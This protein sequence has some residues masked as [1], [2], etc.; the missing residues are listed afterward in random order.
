VQFD[1][2]RAAQILEIVTTADDAFAA[3]ETR[4]A[5]GAAAAGDALGDVLIVL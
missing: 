5:K 1:L 4:F 2:D 3:I